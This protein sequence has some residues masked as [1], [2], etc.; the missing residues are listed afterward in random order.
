MNFH[1]SCFHRRLGR[2]SRPFLSGV[3]TK[4]CYKFLI[5]QIFSLFVSPIYHLM[6]ITNYKTP[7]MYL[8]PPGMFAYEIWNYH[9]YKVYNIFFTLYLR[10]KLCSGDCWKYESKLMFLNFFFSE[11]DQPSRFSESKIWASI[12]DE[13][14][15][16][17]IST[18]CSLFILMRKP[19]NTGA[20]HTA[21]FLRGIYLIFDIALLLYEHWH[22]LEIKVVL[23]CFKTY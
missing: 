5:W 11:N 17:R 18:P 22:S 8:H 6:K 16:G 3:S 14:M 21:F 13:W 7:C 19:L 15:G 23:P 4:I 1:P 10:N 20:L 12:T 2:P 9:F